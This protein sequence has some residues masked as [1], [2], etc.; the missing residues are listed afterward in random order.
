MKSRR[1]R[2]NTYKQRRSRRTSKRLN[3]RRKT[4]QRG[5]AMRPRDPIPFSAVVEHRPLEDEMTG[6]A[7]MV[8]YETFQQMKENDELT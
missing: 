7:R 4:R 8:P 2:R 6:V 5:G 1:N 3:R